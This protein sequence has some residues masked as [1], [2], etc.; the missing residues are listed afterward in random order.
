MKFRVGQK[1]HGVVGKAVADVFEEKGC[2]V[3]WGTHRRGATTE[4]I[5]NNSDII[6]VCV[7]SPS[8]YETEKADLSIVDGIMEDIYPYVKDTDK[9]VVIKSTILP[10]STRRYEKTYPGMKLA[11]NPEF[12]TAANPKEDFENQDR[13]VIGATLPDVREKLKEFYMSLFPGV[14]IFMNDNPTNAELVK[15]MANLFLATKVLFANEFY[16]IVNHLDGDYDFVKNGMKADYRIGESHL[17]VTNPKGFSGMCFPK[18]IV[19]LVGLCE[20][21]GWDC[22]LLR[23]VWDKNKKIRDVHD[24]DKK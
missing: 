4:E 3:T 2:Q 10:G 19:A 14:P 12:L 20:D 22:S 7:P 9:I 1:G 8:N 23:T 15:Y 24:W 18:D 11:F 13:I 6:F 5:V 16:D 17:D 21:N